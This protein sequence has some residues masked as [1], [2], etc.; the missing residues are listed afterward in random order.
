MSTINNTLSDFNL[1]KEELKK[2]SYE[3]VKIDNKYTLD[4]LLDKLNNDLNKTSQDRQK[5][6][7]E[8]LSKK[9]NYEDFINSF[10]DPSYKYHS[11]S[12]L[13]DKL[14]HLKNAETSN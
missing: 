9:I 4:N 11:L 13:K 5:V 6:I 3:K 1:S 8:F 2:T 12:I 10:K 7:S 14:Y